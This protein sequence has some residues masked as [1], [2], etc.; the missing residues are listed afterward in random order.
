MGRLRQIKATLGNLNQLGCADNCKN[1]Q[2]LLE[3]Y[4]RKDPLLSSPKMNPENQQIKTGDSS[5]DL[6]L[7]SSSARFLLPALVG[8]SPGKGACFSVN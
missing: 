8:S 2:H 5:Q 4:G 1:R 6:S 7:G 3:T